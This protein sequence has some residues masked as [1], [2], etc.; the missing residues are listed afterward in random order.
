MGAE[1]FSLLPNIVPALATPNHFVRFPLYLFWWL[2]EP[3]PP[4]KDAAAIGATGKG[5]FSS[6]RFPAFSLIL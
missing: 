6:E 2:R 4:K 1:R 3:Q 5:G